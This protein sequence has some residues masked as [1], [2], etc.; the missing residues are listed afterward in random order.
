[1][2]RQQI[3]DVFAKD[4]PNQYEYGIWGPTEVCDFAEKIAKLSRRETMER[5]YKIACEAMTAN[6]FTLLD[7]LLDPL[8]EE[9]RLTTI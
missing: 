5:C 6:D 7:P 2:N 9:I 8:L 1:M 4:N 3:E